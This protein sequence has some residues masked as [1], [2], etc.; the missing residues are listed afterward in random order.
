MASILLHNSERNCT[1]TRRYFGGAESNKVPLLT[2]QMHP[3]MQVASAQIETRKIK[4]MRM[5]LNGD[6]FRLRS[7]VAVHLI[8]KPARV[9]RL[10]VKVWLTRML[11]T[12][13]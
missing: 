5:H 2:N 13:L 1:R 7:A 10:C 8:D 11:Q 4:Q 3:C 6:F 9:R 12:L